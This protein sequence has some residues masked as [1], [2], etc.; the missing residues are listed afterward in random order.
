MIHYI[1]RRLM[2][3]PITL[4]GIIFFNFVIINLAPGDP[5][6]VTEISPQ[7]AATRREGS[8]VAFGMDDRYLQ[9][10]EHYGLTLPV[11]FNNWPHISLH[12]VRHDLWSLVHRRQ[13][14][15][16]QVELSAREYDRL[17]ITLGDQARFVMPHLL[18][19]INDTGNDPALRRMASRFFARGA[20]RQAF[21]GANLT[22]EQRTINRKV[23]ADN[24]LVRAAILA[25]EDTPQITSEKIKTLN[26]WYGDNK[27][28][29]LF[30]PNMGQKLRIF[31]FETR[32]FRYM[33]RVLTLDFGTMR[34][35]P[36]KTVIH[37][38][39]S[40]FKYSL[41]LAIIPMFLTF[42]LCLAF[43]FLMACWQN[44][45]PDISLNMIFLILYAIPVF[46]VAPLL[47]EWV[48]QGGHFPFTSVPIPL[49]GF[50]S[51]ENVYAEQTSWQRLL[52]VLQHLYL[53]LIAIIYGSLAV[54]SRLARTAILEVLHQD[55]VR[56]ARAKGVSKGSILY[57]HV[58][59]NASITLVT[60][61]AGSLGIV[62]GGSLIVETLFDIHGFGKFFYD[63]VVNWDYN[64]IMFSA[65]AGSFLTLA[66]YLVADI[67]YTLLDPRLTLE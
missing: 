22:P 40:R 36:T 30:E 35:D 29:Y 17:R 63:A 57:K 18:Q 32:F 65:F 3:L 31:F 4:F 16:S 10:R 11:L 34:N 46:V 43:G 54:Q 15:A 23:S 62:L 49:S 9:F 7:G 2:L 27:G 26:Q 52:D 25:P 61:I 19:I 1:L 12:K 59:R 8:S 55:Y 45:W 6:T 33:S 67:A 24:E 60:S 28:A 13:N 20:T 66:G 21:V 53:P 50:T 47:I 14:S 42:F 39:V 41:T 44:H 56:T 58:G 64:V 38:V 51:P 5:T 37:E 48:A